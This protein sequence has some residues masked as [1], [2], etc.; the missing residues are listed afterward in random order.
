M[1]AVHGQPKETL[2]SE[3][4]ESKGYEREIYNGEIQSLPPDH[5]NYLVGSRAV[6][7]FL[8]TIELFSPNFFF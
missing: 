3:C 7:V 8:G 5:F 4:D 2:A 6:L 1:V